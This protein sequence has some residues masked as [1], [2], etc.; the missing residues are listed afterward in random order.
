[1]HNRHDGKGGGDDET[2]DRDE[3]EAFWQIGPVGFVNSAVSG[4]SREILNPWAPARPQ[5][6][7]AVDKGFERVRERLPVISQCPLT[8]R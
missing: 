7:I 2:R 6:C 3:H 4:I 8:G 5:L 1:M